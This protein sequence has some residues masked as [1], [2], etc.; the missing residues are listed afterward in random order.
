M[1]INQPVNCFYI[2]DILVDIDRCR[3]QRGGEIIP[4][5]PKVIQVLEVLARHQGEVVSHQTLLDTVWT[6]TIVE[7]SALQRCIAQLRKAFGDDARQQKIITTYPKRGYSLVVEIQPVQSE[8]P[9]SRRQSHR[10]WWSGLAA[11]AVLLAAGLAFIGSERPGT[12]PDDDS[13][14]ESVAGASQLDSSAFVNATQEHN[15]FPAYSPDGRYVVYPRY[16]EENL[17]HLWARDL[18]YGNDFMITEEAGQYAY[19]AWSRDGS[20]MLFVDAACHQSHCPS[21]Q[22][23]TLKSVTLSQSETNAP[24][25]QKLIDCS[26][27]RLLSPQWLSKQTL[28]VL[29]LKD[30]GAVLARYDVKLGSREV[31][32]NQFDRLPY[33]LSFSRQTGVLTIMALNPAGQKELLF[34]DLRSGAL[35]RNDTVL[36]P[37]PED[38]YPSSTPL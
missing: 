2:N 12:Q 25:V 18:A 32:Y 36:T 21:G 20:Q 14:I 26:P 34:L 28:A 23:S 22:C 5:E 27:D 8:R 11:A 7:P 37:P 10:P 1:T 24:T 3:L 16:L 17:A 13:V 4:L 19:L 31:L 6:Y 33:D 15:D 9:D 29:E 35:N 30:T 38:W